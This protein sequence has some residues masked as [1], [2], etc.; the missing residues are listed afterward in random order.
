M[1]VLGLDPGF[2]R[3]GWAVM[4]VDGAG[5]ELLAL[6]V[7]RT[8]KS[9]AKRNVRKASDDH[10]RGQEL[11]RELL[12]TLERRK[13][14]AVTAEAISFVRSSSVMAQIGR[15]WGMLDL[16][17]VQRS[18]PLLEV[19]PQ[20]LKRA[21]TG[22]ADASK[23]EVQAA[24]DARFGGRVAELLAGIRAKGDHEHPVDAAGSIVACLDTDVIR[25]GRRLGA[26]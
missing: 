6:G 15:A 22:R 24:L 16:A 10:R 20:D 3:F 26:A 17:C 8:D 14:D 23:L 9:D 2:R 11:G 21:V 12:A 1:I 7:W 4:R 5:E 19:S 18:L 13:P 25:M